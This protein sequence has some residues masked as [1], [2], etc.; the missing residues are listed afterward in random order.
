MP[1]LL[2][3]FIELMRHRVLILFCLPGGGLLYIVP[4]LRHTTVD[5]HVQPVVA[6][7]RQRDW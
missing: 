4:W 1:F 7:D 6:A 5:H 2:L 3:R